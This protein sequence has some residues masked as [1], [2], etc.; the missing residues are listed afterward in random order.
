MEYGK[1]VLARFRDPQHAGRPDLPAEAMASGRAGKRRSGSD[2]VIY[3]HIVGDEISDARF[4]A[5]GCPRTIAA[6]DYMS[7]K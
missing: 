2:V 6:A 5:Y 3:L 4:E 1:A 7:G